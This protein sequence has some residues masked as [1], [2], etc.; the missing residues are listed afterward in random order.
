[1]PREAVVKGSM[2]AKAGFYH[3][4]GARVLRILDD[5]QA[6]NEDLDTVIKQTS[7]EFHAEYTHRTVANHEAK[8]LMISSEQTWAI[9]SVDSSQEIQVLN[10]QLPVNVDDSLTL[11]VE[12]NNLTVKRYCDGEIQYPVN[13]QVLVARCIIQTLRDEGYIDV[14]IPFGDRIEWLDTSNRRNPSIFMDLVVAY[15]GM[16]RHQRTKDS[17]G[18]Y[19][20]TEEDFKAARV[21]F[22][23][24]D[25][26]EL[27][28]RLTQRERET[29]EFMVS[30]PEGITQDD[31]SEHLGIS[32]QRAG[33]ILYGQK[34][35][36]GLMQKVQLKEDKISEMVRISEDKS[37]TLYR[38]IYS[39][40][41]YDHFAGFDAV[42]RLKPASEDGGKSRNDGA[43]IDASM[44]T[45]SSKDGA[46]IESKKEKEKDKE[47]RD[48]RVLSSV[49]G[50]SSHENEEDTC[51]TCFM[52]SDGDDD[53][54]VNPCD[55][56]VMPK[57]SGDDTCA[58]SGVPFCAK[59]GADLT[60]CGTVTKNGK[61][62]CALPGCGYPARGSVPV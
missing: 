39:L 51:D 31:L 24:K 34:Y 60:G 26:E 38:T 36:G 62:Y 41:N 58:V 17:E 12:V 19:L 57:D 2:S 47:K 7:S 48:N 55:T 32:R 20:A 56:C 43:S 50:S 11:T 61:F 9:T 25:G 29:I 22:T 27:V 52:P 3:N 14:R 15:T 8:T 35:T 10:R 54:C 1:M 37:R 13:E 45:N 33:Q 30:R 4:D 5:Y 59:C 49:E 6:G 21:L 46:S 53:T 44:G 28:K 42:V 40:K 16:F 23:D 18:Y